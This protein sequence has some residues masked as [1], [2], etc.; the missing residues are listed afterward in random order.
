MKA[1]GKR[2]TTNINLEEL[3]QVYFDIEQV[4]YG[5]IF[6]VRRSPNDIA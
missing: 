1:F 3:V 6:A 4:H 5:V 2:D